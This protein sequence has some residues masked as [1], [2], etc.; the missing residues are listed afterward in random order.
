MEIDT[1]SSLLKDPNLELLEMHL[2]KPNI[3]SILKIENT[4]IRHSNFLAWL[5]D[6]NGSHNLNDRFLKWFLKEVFSDQKINWIDEFTVDGLSFHNL[7]IFREYKNI[8]IILLSDDFVIAIENKILSTEHSNQLSRYE[9]IVKRDFKNINHAF[10]YLTLAG[11]EP[12]KLEN[13]CVY[14]NYSYINIVTIL[15][16]IVTIYNDILPDKALVYINDYI[17]VLRRFVMQED[18][19]TKIA[20]ELYKNHKEAIDFIIETKPDRLLSIMPIALDVI[21][22]AGYIP[23][24]QNKGYARFLTPEINNIIPKNSI[25]GWKNQ[26]L[27]LFEISM[28]SKNI[29][30]KT[31][32]A[33]GNENQRKIIKKA[34]LSIP[35]ARDA[36]TQLWNTIHSKKKSLNVMDEKYEDTELLK[37]DLLL[38]LQENKDFISSVSQEIIKVKDEIENSV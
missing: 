37:K 27:F 10:I 3:F 24:T 38:F 9:E 11:D 15:N 33:P 17:E 31:V 35:G 7:Q 22:E 12:E 28:W 8:D 5:L 2:A 26:E 16:Q 4:E 18:Q 34:L 13:S 25:N 32:I 30:L 29:V 36:K 6:P 20:Q 1:L 19:A 23:G 14:V 21:N